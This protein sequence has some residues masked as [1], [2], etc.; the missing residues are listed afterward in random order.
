MGGRAIRVGEAAA[1]AGVGVQ[2]LHYYERE[3]LIDA[4]ARSPAGYREYAPATIDRVRAIKRAQRMGFTLGE[5]RELIEV[6]SARRPM[7]EL[8]AITRTRIEAIDERIAE[9]SALRAALTTTLEACAC[10]GDAGRCDLLD[11]LGAD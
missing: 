8:A 10:G 7:G 11:G 2:T 3:Q 9:L 4:P 6:A 5:I 1:A